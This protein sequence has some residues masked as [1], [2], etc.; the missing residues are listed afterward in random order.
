MVRFVNGRQ[1]QLQQKLYESTVK[2]GHLAQK[3][4]IQTTTK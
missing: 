4:Q 1:Q 3:S 2:S